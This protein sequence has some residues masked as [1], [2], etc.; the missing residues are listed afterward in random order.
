MK[1]SSNKKST[2]KKEK[3]KSSTRGFSKDD[4]KK[5]LNANSPFVVKEAYNSIRTNL[6]F[7][8]QGEKCPVFVVTSPAANNGKSIN[9]INLAVSF[10]QMG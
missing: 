10:A 1:L 8:Q 9:S 5:I 3:T 7:I 2:D 6:L 4:P